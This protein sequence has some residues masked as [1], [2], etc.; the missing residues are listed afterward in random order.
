MTFR[1]QLLIVSICMDTS[2]DF[3]IILNQRV[4]YWHD[5]PNSP[6]SQVIML[7]KKLINL[8]GL[9][10]T[11][12]SLCLSHIFEVCYRFT[13]ARCILDCTIP[14]NVVLCMNV[15]ETKHFILLLLI[16]GFSFCCGFGVLILI[17]R[18]T[19]FAGKAQQYQI[20]FILTLI[21]SIHFPIYP[22]ILKID[23]WLKNT[24]CLWREAHHLLIA[25]EPLNQS[26]S[27]SPSI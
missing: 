17:G 4:F 20:N 21:F 13:H 27:Y 25:N 5:S 6:F 1:L 19:Q 14:E 3:H 24:H 11:V 26:H 8:V 16:W 2:L 9:Y 12:S 10:A 7:A 22:C 23:S 18:F 15:Q